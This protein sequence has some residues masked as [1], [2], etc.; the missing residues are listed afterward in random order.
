[1][2]LLELLH[3]CS[4]LFECVEQIHI[5]GESYFVKV[6]VVGTVGENNVQHQSVRDPFYCLAREDNVLE[7]FDMAKTRLF[8][9]SS[10]RFRARLVS[11]SQGVAKVLSDFFAAHD[12]RA[13]QP[14]PLVVPAKKAVPPCANS[15][16]D[17]SNNHRSLKLALG[18]RILLGS[19]IHH[20]SKIAVL[21]HLE[22]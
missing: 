7:T 21:N 3:Q 11:G 14:F 5:G 6:V 9:Q 2:L 18:L 1:M 12:V 16:D 22:T 4:V 19:P 20:L 13:L 10:F 17:V 8:L 15:I